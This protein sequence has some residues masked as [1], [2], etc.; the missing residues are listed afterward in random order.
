MGRVQADPSLRS[1]L[2]QSALKGFKMHWIA[3]MVISPE[4]GVAK[5]AAQARGRMYIV[6]VLGS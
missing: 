5:R 1:R 4:L 3:S 6:R 2:S